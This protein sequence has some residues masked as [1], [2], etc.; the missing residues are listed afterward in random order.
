MPSAEGKT[1][2]AKPWPS[3]AIAGGAA[4]DNPA[5]EAD[6]TWQPYRAN[7]AYPDYASG[8]GTVTAAFAES[9]RMYLGDNVPLTL[10]SVPSAPL[11]NRSYAT[12][13]ALEDDAFMA[14]IYAGRNRTGPDRTGP[15]H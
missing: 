10:V 3:Q 4:D 1:T 2:S 11:P 14:R 8:H 6:P 7:P 9:V 5:T 12:L 15:D 13:S